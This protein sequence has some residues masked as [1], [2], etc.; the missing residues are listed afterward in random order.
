MQIQ[1]TSNFMVIWILCCIISLVQIYFSEEIH[2]LYNCVHVVLHLSNWS[3]IY[4]ALLIPLCWCVKKKKILLFRLFV[5]KCIKVV[6]EAKSSQKPTF[7]YMQSY[8]KATRASVI[9][10]GHLHIFLTSNFTIF[11]DVKLSSIRREMD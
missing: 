4:S 2:I 3:S 5:Y 7:S 10:F 1:G 6:W 8:Q 9:A 11:R